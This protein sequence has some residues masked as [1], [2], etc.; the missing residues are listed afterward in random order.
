MKV[1]AF[2]ALVFACVCGHAVADVI[3]YAGVYD[4]SG[5]N[6]LEKNLGNSSDQVS[7]SQNGSQASAYAN[8][9]TGILSGVASAAPAVDA[10]HYAQFSTTIRE[11]ITFSPGASGI[12]YLNWHWDGS[13]S[14]A[15]PTDVGLTGL[16]SIYV[17][18][19]S[20]ASST[21]HDEH[22]LTT[23]ACV[24]GAYTSCT[25]GSVVNESGQIAF[26]IQPGDL[27]LQESITGYAT[28]GGTTDFSHTG[29]LSL[30]LPEGVTYT[31]RSG[32]FLSQVATVPEPSTLA[33]LGIS[34]AGLGFGRRKKT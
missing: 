23:I 31:S 7:Y 1:R 11:T 15:A 26:L 17:D 33:L 6:F 24:L 28:M 19:L 22:I 32:S 20:S 30:T 18:Y 8:A 25:S 2:F 13:S 3:V 14:S 29:T 16:L 27:F 5:S 10:I 12:G 21:I 4:N 34:L 9:D